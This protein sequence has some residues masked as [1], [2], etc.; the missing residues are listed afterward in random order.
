MRKALDLRK[1]KRISTEFLIELAECVLKNKIFEHN[2]SL[3]KQLEE[4][5]LKQKWPYHM[6]SFSWVILEKDLLVIVTFHL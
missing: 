1:D 5:Q 2:L 3:Y 6:L 4:L